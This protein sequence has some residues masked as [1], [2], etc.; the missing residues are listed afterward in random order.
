MVQKTISVPDSIYRLLKKKKKDDE[1]FAN[2]FMR[3]LKNDESMQTKS[4]EKYFGTLEEMSEG[5][6]DR[7][8]HVLYQDRMKTKDSLSLEGQHK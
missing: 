1:S 7:I 2:F 4:M 8:L 5:E 3:L 6:W